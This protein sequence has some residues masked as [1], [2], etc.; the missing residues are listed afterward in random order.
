VAFLA[1][2]IIVF[3]PVYHALMW[4]PALPNTSPGG[5]G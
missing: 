3:P 4:W 5:G 2:L 1:N